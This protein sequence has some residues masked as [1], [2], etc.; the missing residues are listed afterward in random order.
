MI[1]LTAQ[2]LTAEA[3]APFGELIL[4]T[5]GGNG[6]EVALDLSQGT[7]RYS[8]MRLT[9][10]AM[11]FGAIARHQRVTQCLGAVGGRD[12]YIAVAA[13]YALPATDLSVITAFR[14]PGDAVIMLRRGTWHAGPHFE[15][16]TIDFTNLE[17]ADTNEVDFDVVDL[18]DSLEIIANPGNAAFYTAEMRALQD[19]FDSRRLADRLEEMFV[20]TAIGDRARA[21]IERS[22]MFFLATANAAGAPDCSYKGGRPGFVQILDENTLAFP[23]YDGN[24]MYRSLGNIAANPAVG[25][26]FV[27]FDGPDRHRVNGLA[28]LHRDPES[29]AL[30]PGAEA[31]VRVHTGAVFANCG[32][33]VHNLRLGEINPYVPDARGD[34]PEPE[35]KSYTIFADT[36]PKRGA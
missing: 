9:G 16:G 20:K 5:V 30:F 6:V 24:G 27:D 3:F 26:L 34:A 31:V 22:S 33:Y 35:W 17:L 13:E 2:P 12:W 25:L 19:T 18:P 36:R 14:V 4:P 10:R 28:T 21:I 23:S 32:R 1:Q 29:L 15:G 7:P 11:R 8:V